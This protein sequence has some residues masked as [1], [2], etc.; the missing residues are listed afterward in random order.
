MKKLLF[1]SLALLIAANVQAQSKR[2]IIP[3]HLKQAHKIIKANKEE[4]QVNLHT[5]R[6]D[7]APTASEYTLFS[8]GMSEEVIGTTYYDLQTNSSVQ[9]RL[10]VHQDNT[11]SATWTMSPDAQSNFPN[12]GTGYNYYDGTSWMEMPATRVEAERTGWPS[13][14]GL[15]GGELISSHRPT[16]AEGLSTTIASRTEKGSGDWSESLLPNSDGAVILGNGWPR[17]KVSGEDGQSIHIISHSYNLSDPVGSSID[18]YISYSRSQDGG[19]TFDIVDLLFD[20]IGSDFYP[21]FG[22][23]AYALDVKGNTVAF[24]L[25]GPWT[26]VILMKSIDNGTTWTKT[27]VKEHPIPMF[28][29]SITVDSTS[30]PETDGYIEN[31][32]QSFSLSLDDD[33]NAHIFYGLMEYTNSNDEGDEEGAY[34]YYILSDGLAYWNEL[35]QTEE[36]IAGV[37]DANGNDTLDIQV[38]E[39]DSSLLVAYYGKSL[40]SFP[41]SAVA[42]NGDIYLIYSSIIEYFYQEQI[43]IGNYNDEIFLEHYRHQYIMRSQDAGVTWSTPYDLMTETTDPLKGNPLQ[44]GV[45][46]CISN[47]VNDNVYLTYQ[48]D[49]YPGL[50]LQGDE[51]PITE[52]SIVFMTVPID[53]FESLAAE[54]IKTSTA[55]FGI[56]PNPTRNLINVNLANNSELATIT[57][58]NIL[59]KSVLTTTMNGA[60]SQLSL[61]SLIN[62]IYFI[63]IETSQ[64]KITKSILK[65]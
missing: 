13:I 40:T 10:F 43:D 64:D 5:S 28:N 35:T 59:G 32:D 65:N 42:D 21:G 23:D 12:R 61:A 22:G 47:I 53:G 8:N 55:D 49:I 9:N 15:N 30:F 18:N 16:T 44:E 50:N 41:S 56:Y 37:T 34:S 1:S 46:G 4:A 27:I 6:V 63:T 36:V 58:S 2:Q 51:D 17:M 31:S 11:I 52:N 39:E 14:A 45:Y 29:D 24:V 62:G 54:E 57:I 3:A 48:S 20:E 33:G 25:G 7:Y 19:E 38:S 26:D 60:N